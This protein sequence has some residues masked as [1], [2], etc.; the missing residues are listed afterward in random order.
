MMESVG[1]GVDEI[2][3]TR[4]S[5]LLYA[6]IHLQ[7]KVR[8]SELESGMKILETTH[9]LKSS[10]IYGCSSISSNTPS[11]SEN[12]EE[13][14][15]FRMLVD[16]ELKGN[17][18]F[19][20]W[21]ADG[22]SDTHSGYNKLKSKLLSK[23]TFQQAAGGGSSG[24]GDGGPVSDEDESARRPSKEQSSEDKSKRKRSP[25]PEGS[26]NATGDHIKS[27]ALFDFMRIVYEDSKQ[28]ATFKIT[29]LQIKAI[30]DVE[31][32]KQEVEEQLQQAKKLAVEFDTLR[33]AK[34]YACSFVLFVDVVT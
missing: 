3:T 1:L 31:K 20:R 6:Y 17:G 29:Q 8:G 22:Y 9:G 15:A 33:R 7:R 13:H 21:T 23:R 5:A 25:S 16:H 18:N 24:G 19:H 10:Y 4:H 28:S 12:M 14:P 2:V 27:S 30:D 34:V 26:Q 11:V 32:K